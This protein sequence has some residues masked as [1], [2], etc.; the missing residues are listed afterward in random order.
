MRTPVGP[1]A[2]RSGKV[3]WLEWGEEAF[4]RAEGEDKPVVL[5][6]TA[7]W[8]APGHEMERT[9]FDDDEV[10]TLLNRD[11]VPIR[12]D[13]DRRPDINE[14]YNLDGWPT[15]AFLTPRGSI[16][17]GG[18]FMAAQDLRVLLVKL[19]GGYR[20]HREQ[21]EE[22][23]ARREEKIAKV[24]QSKH[25]GLAKLT[26]EVFRKTVRGIVAGFDPVNAGFGKAP[27]FP[28]VSCLRV[29]L[30]ALAETGGADF[31]N[32]LTRTLDAMGD[33]G[34]Y[35][36][37]EGGFFHCVTNDTWAIP[38]FE[39]MGEDNAGL[40]TLYL[41]ASLVTG[42][43]KYRDKALHAAAWVRTR[44]SD[45]DRGVFY[46]SQASDSDYYMTSVDDRKRREP[47]PVSCAASR[48]STSARSSTARCW[49]GCCSPRC[50][51]PSPS[52]CGM[53]GCPRHCF[54]RW[55]SWWPGRACRSQDRKPPPRKSGSK[56]PP[57]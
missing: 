23:I 44:L 31:G 34:M 12:I 55:W 5:F 25:T 30:Q 29:V 18:T 52:C 45:P 36:A 35:D 40:I 20:S 15:T 56:P 7:S 53:P 22:E 50:A 24:L 47:P 48:P 3:G 10:A 16:I 26:P 4:R 33:R 32:V 8:C 6:I 41:D 2:V 9:T 39:K 13:S 1:D 11:Y 21:I 46:G 19:L 38:R 57:T 51:S 54:S 37:V 43:E 14:R 27:K 42:E 28:M 49:P 17:G